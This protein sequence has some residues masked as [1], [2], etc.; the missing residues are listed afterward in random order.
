MDTKKCIWEDQCGS[1]CAGHCPDYTPADGSEE[2]ERFYTCVLIE[3]VQAYQKM[4][5][6]YD[7]KEDGDP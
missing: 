2:N 1:E 6:D 7:D 4:I 3:N 5:D